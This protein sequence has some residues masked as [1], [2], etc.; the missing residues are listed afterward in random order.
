MQSQQ[1]ISLVRLRML[2]F[3]FSCYAVLASCAWKHLYVIAESQF[4]NI[5]FDHYINGESSKTDFIS[6]QL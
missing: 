1:A 4:S 3:A 5:L 2:F 6:I